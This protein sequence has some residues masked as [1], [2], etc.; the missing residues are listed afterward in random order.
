MEK[1]F[2]LSL[3]ELIE[4]F[5]GGTRSGR[6]VKAVQVGGPLGAYVPPVAVGCPARTTKPMRRWAR[7]SGTE[8]SWCMTT[9]PTWPPWLAMR[10]NSGALE[11]CGKC[12]PCRIG[13]TRG[14]EVIDRITKGPQK[15]QQVHLLRDLCDT[16]LHGSLCAMG[17]MTPLSRAVGLEPLSRGFR[18][19]IGAGPAGCLEEHTHG[20]VPEFRDR[21]RHP[22]ERFD[23]VGEPADR[24]VCRHRAQGQ[25]A[26]ARG[27]GRLACTCPSCA[28][29]TAWSL[30][31]PA[32]C[33]SW[34]SRAA[35]ATRR[36]A[37]RRPR[38]AWSVRT[39]S[40]K[41]Q[42]LR[43]GVMELYISDHP[44]DCLT[45]SANGD[46]ELQDMAG[47]T[48]LRNVRYGVAGQEVEGVCGA[49]HCTSAKD[50]SNPY[51][52]YDPSKCIVCNRCVR[53]CEETQG[54]FA[55]TISGRG[56]R[57]PCVAGAGPTFHG[58]RVRELRRMR[59]GLPDGDAAG[60]VGHRAGP[61]RA[62]RGHHLRLLRRGLWLQGGHEGQHG[63]CAWCRG[64]TARPTKAIP[65]SRA[66][67]PGAM[68]PTRTASP[69]R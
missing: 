5:G 67:S 50:E 68:P 37:P 36:P 17:G 65:A 53:A 62:Q 69:R 2:G 14:V 54:T 31:A 28:P 24:R 20:T 64:R 52:T 38:L 47:V 49:H 4:G 12:T 9:P 51:F 35:K 6:P 42:D 22:G 18:P 11:S 43:K 40:P 34:R 29:P 44:L 3:R 26:D 48:G 1:A 23:R 61:A 46:C 8:G 7:C 16:M 66:A 63:V 57:K 13:S 58:Q 30:S 25:F 55:L 59:A 45:C 15:L 19:V 60:K 41:L 39:Q 27:G 56:L 33:A 21:F 32:G 10:W